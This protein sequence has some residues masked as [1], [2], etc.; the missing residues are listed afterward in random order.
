[1]WPE[2]VPPPSGT[3]RRPRARKPTPPPAL[4]LPR[5]FPSRYG[6]PVVSSVEPAIFSRHYFT[7]CMA[8]SFCHD[9]CCSYGVDVDLLHLRAIKTH[10][11]ALEAYT[12]I[13]RDQWFRSTRTPDSEMPGGGSV[14]TRVVRGACVFRDRAGRGCLIHAFCLERGLDYHDL[15]PIV[16]CLFPLTFSGGTLTT[17]PEVD[18]DSLVCLNTGPTLYRGLRGELGFYFGTELVAALDRIEA[19]L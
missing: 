3:P 10:A 16:D 17:A 7:D 8:C 1:M 11:P 13:A 15:K 18:D 9:S 2:P 12:G 4:E 6:V 19:S 14:R 5:A